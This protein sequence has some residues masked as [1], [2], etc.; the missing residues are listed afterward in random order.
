MHE[1]KLSTVWQADDTQITHQKIA[2][3]QILKSNNNG[4]YKETT[5]LTSIW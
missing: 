1:I 4:K 3:K 5:T 2:K